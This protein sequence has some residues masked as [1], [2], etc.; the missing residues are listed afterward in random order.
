VRSAGSPAARSTAN[1][2]T[3]AATSALHRSAASRR[4]F[5]GAPSASP[6]DAPSDAPSARTSSH[7]ARNS[8]SSNAEYQIVEILRGIYGRGF[9]W[10]SG[11]AADRGRAR[12]PSRALECTIGQIDA[13]VAQRIVVIFETQRRQPDPA[14][15][16]YGSDTNVA[17]AAISRPLSGT[18]RTTPRRSR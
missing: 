8:S 6:S 16:Y 11:A 5:R 1:D 9:K 14:P 10:V 17:S 18:L 3:G 13:A 7:D 15:F 4:A 12:T 2:A